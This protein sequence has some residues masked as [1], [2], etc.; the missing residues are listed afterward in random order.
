MKRLRHIAPL[1]LLAAGGCLRAPEIV[2][3]DRSTVLEEEASGSFDALEQQLARAGIA[4]APVPLSPAQLEA[5]GL[6]VPPLVDHAELTDADA[7]D[8]LL[9]QRCIGEGL[10][11]LL[12]DTHA[13][14][15]GHPDR[16]ETD[17]LVD[18]VNQARAQLWRWMQS[19]RPTVSPGD[20][21]SAWRKIHAE[22]VACGAWLQGADGSWGAKGC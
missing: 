9:V 8:A 1:L 2:V 21:R 12:V 14:C 13:A 6:V 22:G 20:L 15:Q 18:R 16:D 4:P 7:V 11:G 19:V 5:L 3:V 10:D 17:R